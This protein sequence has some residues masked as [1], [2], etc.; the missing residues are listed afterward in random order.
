VHVAR[1][2][3]KRFLIEKSEGK[4]YIGNLNGDGRIIL[5]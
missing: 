4:K 3:Q 1:M 2:R 5:K